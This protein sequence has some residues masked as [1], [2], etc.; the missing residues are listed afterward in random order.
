MR[1]S[2]PTLTSSRWFVHDL[3]GVSK[4]AITCAGFMVAIAAGDGPV[5]VTV[6]EFRIYRVRRGILD[7]FGTLPVVGS[8][9]AGVLNDMRV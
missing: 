1:D 4:G 3:I 6:T 5:A 2:T 8:A 7:V 9:V